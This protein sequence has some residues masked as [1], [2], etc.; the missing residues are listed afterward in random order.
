M[1]QR[2]NQCS[3]RYFDPGSLISVDPSETHT[4]I[5]SVHLEWVDRGKA[6]SSCVSFHIL[7]H[8]FQ[9]VLHLIAAFLV[10]REDTSQDEQQEVTEIVRK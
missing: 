5:L 9:T 8:V 6:H 1:G 10:P 2:K 7:R 3:D 4:L